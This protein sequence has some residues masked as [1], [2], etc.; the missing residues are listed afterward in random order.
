MKLDNYTTPSNDSLDWQ[1]WCNLALL[2][3]LVLALLTCGT[4]CVRGKGEGWEFTAVATDVK[5]LDVSAS[6]MRA[7]AVNQSKSVKHGTDAITT[8]AKIRAWLGLANTATT[9]LGDVARKLTD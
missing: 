4:S 9:E 1:A 7:R 3:L 6:G 5:G 2:A 8:M